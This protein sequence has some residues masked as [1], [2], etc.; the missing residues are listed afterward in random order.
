LEVAKV[1]EAARRGWGMVKGIRAQ[2]AA[3]SDV[4]VATA[5]LTAVV[6]EEMAVWVEVAVAAAG[7][8][9]AMAGP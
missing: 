3:T 1:V 8:E 9:E 4:E 6:G 5:L 2:E 7:G